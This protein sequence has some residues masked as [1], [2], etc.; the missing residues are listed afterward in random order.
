MGWLI[1]LAVLVLLAILPLGV[2]AKYDDSGPLVRLIAG[3]IRIQV[4]PG[5]KQKQK[6]EKPQKV[7]EEKPAASSQPA[8]KQKNGGSITD[9][10]PLV[11]LVFD[12]LG[13]FRRKLR[14]E[15]LEMTIVM[16]GGDPCDLG[17]NYGRAWAALGNL[18]PQLERFFVIKKRDLQVNCD[19][20]AD[21][22]LI[23]ARVDVTITV[24]RI[25]ALLGVHGFRAVREYLKI[26]KLRKG[27][28]VK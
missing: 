28:A 21:K 26:M 6:K 4:Y 7:E 14:V 16:A 17:I 9:F 11:Q 3:P 1:A 12:F 5:K 24:G 18:I 2:S 10:L 15:R 19:F 25:F 20:T 13:N 27:G 8:A 23:Y 22:T